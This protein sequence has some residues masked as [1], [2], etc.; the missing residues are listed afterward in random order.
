MR[1]GA[2]QPD[3]AAIARR[4]AVGGPLLLG[5]CEG[6]E[7]RERRLVP[8]AQACL[9]LCRAD[10][11]VVLE[12]PMRVFAPARALADQLDLGRALSHH[13]GLDER[14]ERRHGR[15]G[16]GT[17]SR[18]LVSEDP[19]VAVVV[20]RNRALD[21]RLSED[22][23]ENQH[24]MLEA[25]VLGIRLDPGER[26]LR[27]CALDL[28]LGHERKMLAVYALREDHRALVGEEVE[29]RQVANRVLLEEDVARAACRTNALA[30]TAAPRRKLVRRDPPGHLRC[31]RQPAPFRH[32][33]RLRQPSER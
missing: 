19:G 20:G 14:C 32:G 22:P 12:Q 29:A 10:P 31:T 15:S 17:E 16:D 9:R 3:L 1:P 25:R 27:A 8:G 28:E 11:A 33:P 13:H 23:R 2:P 5:V 7:H 21:P 24:R 4:D 26:R 30:D 18:A 6:C